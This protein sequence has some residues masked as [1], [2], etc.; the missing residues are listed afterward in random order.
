MKPSAVGRAHGVFARR[1][2]TGADDVSAPIQLF[3]AAG[4]GETVA[5]VHRS[6]EL[7]TLFR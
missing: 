1:L 3:L 2:A 7:L 5:F 4:S 6:P